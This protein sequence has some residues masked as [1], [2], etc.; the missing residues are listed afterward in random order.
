MST[1]A[2]ILIHSNLGKEQDV[3]SDLN[4][5]PEVNEAHVVMGSYDV[6]ALVSVEQ[7]KEL[8]PLV[9]NKIRTISGVRQTMTIIIV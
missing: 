5:I 4:K 2:Y 7:T 1:Q 8:R 6:I 3:L 9:T